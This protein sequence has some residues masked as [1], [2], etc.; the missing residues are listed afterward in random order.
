MSALTITHQ[1]A[2]RKA[3]R[4]EAIDPNKSADWKI[5]WEI[6][7]DKWVKTQMLLDD[8]NIVNAPI[9]YRI[10]ANADSINSGLDV[11]F[12]GVK[13]PCESLN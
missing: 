1:K 11:P 13:L 5:L 4:V 9:Q 8:L 7:E 2:E 10:V 12:R 6:D 3:L